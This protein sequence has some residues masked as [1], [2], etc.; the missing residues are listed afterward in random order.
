MR[1][2]LTL[3]TRDQ[4]C[5]EVLTRWIA[6]LLTVDEAAG[7]LGLSERSSWRLRQRLIPSL[8]SSTLDRDLRVSFADPRWATSGLSSPPSTAAWGPAF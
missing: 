1:E 4:Q 6:G 5:L 7:L 2:R 8:G 3:T